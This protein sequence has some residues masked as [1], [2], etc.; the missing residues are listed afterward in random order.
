M[1]LKGGISRA[2]RGRALALT[3]L[4]VS[5]PRSR[6]GP[7]A[8]LWPH[9]LGETPRHPIEAWVPRRMRQWRWAR[10]PMFRGERGGARW[11]IRRLARR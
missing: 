11:A 3:N 6:R 2:T 4:I 9:P 7:A 10:D 1:G 5:T 8:A